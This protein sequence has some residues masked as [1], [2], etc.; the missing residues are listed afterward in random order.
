MLALVGKGRVAPAQPGAM[1]SLCRR[2]SAEGASLALV[3]LRPRPAPQ[4]QCP[5]GL[6]V[7]SRLLIWRNPGGNWPCDGAITRS[8][9]WPSA[10]CEKSKGYHR[11]WPCYM[12]ALGVVT[13]NAVAVGLQ[14]FEKP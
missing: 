2:G 13:G 3:L 11:L 1:P 12:A 10:G 4:P 6:S 5:C 7:Q 8:C 14:H 9:P